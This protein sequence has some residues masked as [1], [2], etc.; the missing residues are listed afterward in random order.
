MSF[1]EVDCFIE[2]TRLFKEIATKI[3]ASGIRLVVSPPTE[4]DCIR[5]Q[6]D[7]LKSE[8]VLSLY[9]HR[10]GGTNVDLSLFAHEPEAL[11]AVMIHVGKEGQTYHLSSDGDLRA[12][13]PEL[14]SITKL[15]ENPDF[16]ATNVLMAV[17]S[18]SKVFRERYLANLSS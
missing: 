3:E 11:L 16:S 4:L 15:G 14:E 17:Q 12:L 2:A 7:G 9:R 13:S 1:P 6:Q 10:N 18:M 8:L 5:L